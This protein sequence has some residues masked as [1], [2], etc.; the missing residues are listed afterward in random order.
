MA[1]KEQSFRDLHA[2]FAQVGHAGVFTFPPE[3]AW[4]LHMFQAAAGQV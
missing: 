3:R 2:A 4:V 1:V